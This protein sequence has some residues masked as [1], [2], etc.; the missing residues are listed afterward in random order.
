MKEA[1]DA[2]TAG[3][4]QPPDY[5]DAVAAARALFAGL[6]GV[7]V[8]RVAVGGQVSSFVGLIAASL[9][10]G[11]VV[12]CP[13]GEFTSVLFPFLVQQHRGIRVR[14]VPFEHLAEAVEPGVSAVAFS[15]VRSDD[16]RIADLQAI[17]RA[18]AG[19]GALT[20]ADATQAAGWLPITAGEVDVLVAG[21]YK[22]LLA[23]RGT[24]FMTVRPEVHDRIVPIHAGWYAGE[25]PWESIYGGPLRLAASARRFDLSPAWLA[26][27]GTVPALQLIDLLGIEAIHRHDTALAAACC[28]ALDLPFSGSAVVSLDMPDGFDATRLRG[29]TAAV[30]AG[31]LRL[32]FHLYNSHDDVDRVAA[33]LAG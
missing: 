32:C 2:W 21:A 29:I 20:L 14:I 1:I 26:W 4:A 19:C 5:D 24:A 17:T 6:V 8:D 28:E 16:G 7:P 10:D 18:A 9:P 27:V 3:N 33:A 30:R 11:A 13:E 23:P 25:Q 15:L 31:R 12:V 22:W